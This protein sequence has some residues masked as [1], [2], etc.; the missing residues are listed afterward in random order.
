MTAPYA[1]V[2]A[3]LR[4]IRW[5]TLFLVYASNRKCAVDQHSAAYYWPIMDTEHV[6][7][8]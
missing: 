2:A 3:G 8:A 6:I 7:M 4:V 1:V 5:G